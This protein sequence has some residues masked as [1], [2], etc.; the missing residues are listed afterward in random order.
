MQNLGVEI[1]NTHNL[2]CW[3]FWVCRKIAISAPHFF[4]SRGRCILQRTDSS[5][6]SQETINVGLLSHPVSFTV[7]FIRTKILII[8]YEIL[9]TSDMYAMH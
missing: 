8:V 2:L 4:F 5:E 7:K 9:T 1:L 3:I 6:I